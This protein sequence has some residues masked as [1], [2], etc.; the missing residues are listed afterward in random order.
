MDK[1]LI[2]HTINDQIGP[3]DIE[4][5]GVVRWLVLSV[6]NG[7]V[8]VEDTRYGVTT[9]IDFAAFEGENPDFT[10][11]GRTVKQVSRRVTKPIEWESWEV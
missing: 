7:T 11:E 10:W 3:D 8:K 5:T 6:G 1:K 9:H 2:N 4:V